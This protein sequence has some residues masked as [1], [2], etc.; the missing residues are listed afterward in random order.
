MV[1]RRTAG[2]VQV[3]P[4]VKQIDFDTSAV[5]HATR[6]IHKVCCLA[7]SFDLIE[8]FADQDLCTAINRRDTAALYDRLIYSLSFQGISD[9]VAENYMQQAVTGQAAAPTLF[10]RLPARSM[11]GSSTAPSRRSFRGS[12]SMQSGGIAISK[13][14]IFATATGSMTGIG[15]K[16]GTVGCMAFAT[17]FV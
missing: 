9:E 13:A 5:D 8:R 4:T 7:G 15:A 12:C 2:Q 1:A 10:K 14:S 17:E 11:P 16:T 6:L 3:R